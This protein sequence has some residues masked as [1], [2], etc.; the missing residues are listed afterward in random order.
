[1]SSFSEDRAIFRARVQE[2]NDRYRQMPFAT[3]DSMASSNMM[4]ALMQG[5]GEKISA[6]TRMASIGAIVLRCKE[7]HI[8]VV[9]QG[10]LKHRFFPGS[11]V[12]VHG[13]YKNADESIDP[14]PHSK[15]MEFY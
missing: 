7:G 1:M 10:F 14:M 13:F 12:M 15:L 3:L 6:G 2:W 11:A 5:P 4:E 9:I 8:Q